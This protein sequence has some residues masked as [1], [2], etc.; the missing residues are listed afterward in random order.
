MSIDTIIYSM[1]KQTPSTATTRTS[2]KAESRLP[3]RTVQAQK[4]NRQRQHFVGEDSTDIIA[5]ECILI[6]VTTPV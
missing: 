5:A 3:H 4:D 1:G 2:F 6:Q